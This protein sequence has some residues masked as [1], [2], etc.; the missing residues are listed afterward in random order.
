MV[1]QATRFNDIASPVAMWLSLMFTYA[2]FIPNTWRRAAVWLGLLAII[3]IAWMAWDIKYQHLVNKAWLHDPQPFSTTA[4]MLL[5]GFGAGVLG[6]HMIGML[7]R[8]VYEARQLG[9][10]HLKHLIGA[11]GMG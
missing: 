8:E 1:L 9:Q 3:P 7:R 11:G 4:I 5:I 6:T 2:I 10:Y